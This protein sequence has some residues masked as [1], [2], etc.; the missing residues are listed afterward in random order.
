M[1]I[2]AATCWPQ[3]PPEKL[4]T[5]ARAAE[6]SGLAELWLWEDCFWGGAMSI[7]SALLAWTDRLPVGIGVLPV[8]LRN[9]ALTAMEV[10]AL[11]RLFPGRVTVGVGHGVQGWMGQVGARVESPVTLLGEYL[12][13]LRGLLRGE[14]LTV[15]G[16][17]VRLDDV[18]LDWPPLTPPAVLAAAAGP[19]TIQLSAQLADGTIL[20]S[21]S[22]VDRVRHARRA[23]DEA[24]A[25]A[26]RPGAHPVVLYLLAVTGPG[27]ARRLEAMERP[28]TIAVAG[29]AHAVADAVR[30]WAAAGVD[31]VVLHPGPD[32][33]DPVAFVRFAAEQVQPLLA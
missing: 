17:Y 8:P 19:R 27:A 14:R 4:R 11:H 33:P 25:A 12:Q 18:A 7:A 20:D 10:A 22:T 1:T 31:K 29:D 15:D 21:A 6:E 16:R 9:V 23:I 32:N 30:F 13:A 24:R 2:L 5:V 28:G 3:V 26:G